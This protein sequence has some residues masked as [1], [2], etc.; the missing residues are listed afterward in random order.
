M[1]AI[2]TN[3]INGVSVEVHSTTVHPASSYGKPVWVDNEGQAYCQVGFERPFYELEIIE[4]DSTTLLD[5]L[6]AACKGYTLTEISNR[7]GISVCNLSRY[8]SG[9]VPLK[10]ETLETIVKAIGKRIEIK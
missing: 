8:L 1:K 3:T 6:K 10:L 4:D 7:T 2:L 5:D 9:S